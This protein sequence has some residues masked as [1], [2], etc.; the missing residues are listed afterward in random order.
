[1]HLDLIGHGDYD[2]D[3]TLLGGTRRLAEVMPIAAKHMMH[4]GVT[5]GIDL[6]SP[7]DILAVR[8][9]IRAGEIPGPRLTIIECENALLPISAARRREICNYLTY[10]ISIV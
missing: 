4:A 1:M 6:G 10:F 2:Q 5:T 7:F 8:E 9:K 3:Y